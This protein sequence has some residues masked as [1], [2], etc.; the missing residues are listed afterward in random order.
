[1]KRKH[2]ARRTGAKA[3][4]FAPASAVQWQ[5]GLPGTNFN[6]AK[7]VG[8]GLK[9]SVIVPLLT[10]LMRAVP[11]PQLIVEQLEDGQ[12][13]A[14]PKHG[15][16]KLLRRPNAFYTRR[17]LLQATVM[18]YAFGEAF[19]IKVRDGFQEVQ[20]LYWAP[21]A[22]VTPKLR[23]PGETD[24]LYYEY[25]IDG[26]T[27]EYEP[28][29]IVHF[30]FGSDPHNP[31]RGY[32]FLAAMFREV[33][34]DDQAANFTA[35]ILR[36]LGIIGL[37]FAPDTGNTIPPG[38]LPDLK[39]YI[40]EN[41][42]GD[43]RG[44]AMAFSI[45]MKAQVLQYNLQGFD[46]GPIRDISEERLSAAI[47][48]PAAVVGFGTGLQQ[49][50]VGATMEQLLR[51]AHYNAVLPMQEDFGEEMDRSLLPDFQDNLNIFR[52]SFDNSKISDLWEDKKDKHQRLR[53]DMLAGGIKLSEFRRDLGYDVKPE[54]EVYYRPINVEAVNKPTD[55]P[56]PAQVRATEKVVVPP[57]PTVPGKPDT[58][59]EPT[60][61]A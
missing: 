23:T 26:G 53:E 6:F 30:R 29:D 59:V 25:R 43:K 33:Y 21:R 2:L 56:Q 15:L 34:I 52:V 42:T 47:G 41:F 57:E 61:G 18:D 9:S 3:V 31:L 37:L 54:H 4:T 55:P 5:F 13:V 32:S 22:L 1:M 51:A 17:A 60:Q 36:N 27:K 20:E 40:K 10:W 39:D 58:S 14:D 50:K 8:D 48:V 12:W 19:W 16:P 49:T 38:K 35:A 24:T 7:E 28:Q 46:V 45:P 11:K 44:N